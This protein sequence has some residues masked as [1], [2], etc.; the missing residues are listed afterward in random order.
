MRRHNRSVLFDGAMVIW[1][2]GTIRGV[3]EEGC[4]KRLQNGCKIDAKIAKHE[5]VRATRL[6]AVGSGLL[7][8]LVN[9]HFPAVHRCFPAVHGCFPAVQRSFPAV[10]RRF[11]AGAYLLLGACNRK[12]F[13]LRL[14]GF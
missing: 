2:D 12:D 6:N 8:G 11:L 13:E 14:S 3:G 5:P 7:A 4:P 1:H 9:R 10:H